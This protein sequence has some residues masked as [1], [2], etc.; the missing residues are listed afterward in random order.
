M[1]S[2]SRNAG[3]NS[4]S[5]S[6]WK[7]VFK[8]VLQI[9]TN[10]KSRKLRPLVLKPSGISAASSGRLKQGSTPTEAIKTVPQYAPPIQAAEELLARWAV[11]I[12][13]AQRRKN[14]D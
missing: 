1:M 12:L 3:R 11:K 7:R 4:A 2:R 8:D 14:N 10:M 5:V 9:R 13:I 6:S